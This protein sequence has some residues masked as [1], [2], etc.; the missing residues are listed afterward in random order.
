[1]KSCQELEPALQE[2]AQ[3]VLKTL[4]DGPEFIGK[5]LRNIHLGMV[6]GTE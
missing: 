4:P 2:I 5:R 3:A 1:M 6:L